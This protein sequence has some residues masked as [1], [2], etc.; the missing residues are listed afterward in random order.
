MRKEKAHAGTRAVET[1]MHPGSIAEP[2]PQ[3]DQRIV[4][5]N[6]LEPGRGVDIGHLG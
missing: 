4:R 3:A 6:G 1:D 5:G 2:H